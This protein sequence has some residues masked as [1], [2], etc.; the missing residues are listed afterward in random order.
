MTMSD[1]QVLKTTPSGDPERGHDEAPELGGIERRILAGKNGS[2][3]AVRTHGADLHCMGGG[4]RMVGEGMGLPKVRSWSGRTARTRTG[5]ASGPKRS[6]VGGWRY[7]ITATGSC[8]A[9]S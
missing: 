3:L 5:A 9:T 6:G 1:G 2:V 8:G 4:R 7:P